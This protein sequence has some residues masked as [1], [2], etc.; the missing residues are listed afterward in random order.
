[1]VA[2]LQEDDKLRGKHP[3]PDDFNYLIARRL[4]E[5]P[6]VTVVKAEEL[7]PSA[8]KEEELKQFLLEKSFDLRRVENWLQKAKEFDQKNI[9]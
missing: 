4:F 2:H 5:K 8:I 9:I 7:I 1:M 3:I 6:N